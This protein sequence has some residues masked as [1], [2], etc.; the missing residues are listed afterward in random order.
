MGEGHNPMRIIFWK[1]LRAYFDSS[2]AYIFIVIFLLLSGAYLA[3]NMFLSNVASMQTFFEVAP[4]LLLLFVPAITMRLV[5]EEKRLG[6]FEILRTKPMST[7]S[8]VVGKFLAAWC[9]VCCALVPTLL[10]VLILQSLGSIDSGATIGGYI[11]LILL[12][13]VFAAAG[14]FGSSLSNNQI[15]ALI[16]SFVISFVLFA[17]D[18]ILI[19]VPLRLVSFVEYLGVGHHFSGL[20][21]GVLDTRDLVYYGSLIVLFVT[22]AAVSASQEP[23]QSLW[24]WRDFQLGR[25]FAKIVVFAGILVFVNLICMRAFVRVDMTDD[26]VYTLS[27][28][29]KNMLGSLDDNF[30]VRAYFSRELPPPYHNHRQSVRQL[31]EEY[32]AYS[33]GRFHY[34][35]VNPS[36]ME[37]EA[38][39]AGITP[40]QVKVIRNNRFQN[41]RAYAGLAFSYADKQDHLPVISSLDRLEYDIT[42]SLMKLTT[43]RLKTIAIATGLGGPAVTE[44]KN[45]ISALSRQ[46]DVTTVDVSARSPIPQT[47]QAL[48]V[49]APGRKLNE[50][51]KVLLDQYVMNGGRIAFFINAIVSDRTHRK[52]RLSDVNLDDMFD[53]YGWVVNKD[54][55]ADVRCAPY[56]LV[57]RAGD[58][59]SVTEILYPFYPVVSE[60]PIET[61]AMRINSPVT[62]S[63][64]SS[65]DTRLASVRGVSSQVVAMTSRQSRRFPAD[66]MSIDPLATLPT[67]TFTEANIPLAA[68]FEGVFRSVFAD[69]RDPVVREAVG[70]IG[71]RPVARSPKTRMAVVGD[72]DFL[73]DENMH[74]YDNAMF[75]VNVVDWL[76]GDSL[77]TTIRSREIAP[78]PLHEVSEETKL[79]VKYVSFGG[80]PGI[81]VIAGIG[82][83]L[84]KNMRRRRH[85]NS[86]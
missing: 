43:A 64:V 40:V 49:I 51:E 74:G 8:I 6:T 16:I 10:Y 37:R 66:S 79:L 24:R 4:V 12:G 60:F 26:K 30:L 63:L 32:R 70:S 9:V 21:R 56:T 85:K 20:A 36:A 39:E 69:S 61:T 14:V 75:G 59:T 77:L 11:G 42:G 45:F 82:W 1:E 48:L 86:F 25:R 68:T 83:M 84:L 22:T 67:G 80:P 65:I 52:A 33:G 62:F 3:S 29:T 7:A 18:K 5:A 17:L 23:G 78:R 19:Y 35:F 57:E 55:V 76:V 81:V 13:G 58:N 38:Q 53:T 34:Q 41:A 71:I 73:L 47:I 72:G 28:V 15:V 2:L 54:I 44:M 27:N 50:A 46:H 31:M